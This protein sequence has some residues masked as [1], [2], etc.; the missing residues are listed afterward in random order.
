MKTYRHYVAQLQE[1]A[2]IVLESHAKG[3][4]KQLTKLKSD[5][6]SHIVKSH[7][8]IL[9][10]LSANSHAQL[11]EKL[12]KT[13]EKLGTEKSNPKQGELVKFGH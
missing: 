2:T 6:P 8:L 9:G 13:R 3:F 11:L 5:K 4:L 10:I 12:H 7:F 1:K